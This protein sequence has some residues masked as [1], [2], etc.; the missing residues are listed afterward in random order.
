LT[1]KILTPTDLDPRR[2]DYYAEASRRR[3]ERGWHRHRHEPKPNNPWAQ[4]KLLLIILGIGIM[5]AI[6]AAVVP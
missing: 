1:A 5:A 6:V 2:L 3:R 4:R